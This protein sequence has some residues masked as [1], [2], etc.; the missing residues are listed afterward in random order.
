MLL[1]NSWHSGNVTS[2]VLNTA[3][4]WRKS[5][6]IKEASLLSL[7]RDLAQKQCNNCISWNKIIEKLE[8]YHHCFLLQK[9]YDE[10]V[11]H[12]LYRNPNVK[13]AFKFQLTNTE[14]LNIAVQQFQFMS[15]NKCFYHILWVYVCDKLFKLPETLLPMHL[16]PDLEFP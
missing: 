16:H 5:D 13:Y 3:I 14:V 9:H 6:R 10:L 8:L 12:L 1:R 4:I 11:L 15:M 2:T 7:A